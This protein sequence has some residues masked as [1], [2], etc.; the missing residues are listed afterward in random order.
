MVL[1]YTVQADLITPTTKQDTTTSPIWGTGS[2]FLSI[3]SS[4]ISPNDLQDADPIIGI[5]DLPNIP[6]QVKSSIIEYLTDYFV[7][8]Q[9]LGKKIKKWS[10]EALFRS[11]AAATITLPEATLTRFIGNI[12]PKNIALG[13][14]SLHSYLNE[15]T[16]LFISY[17][18]L[19]NVS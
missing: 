5:D 17:T 1:A 4:I 14:E 7:K 8:K 16:Y 3:I 19:C 10:E 11:G 9:Q 15:K 6:E 18:F 12:A 2:G 13:K